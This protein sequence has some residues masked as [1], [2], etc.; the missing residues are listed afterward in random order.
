MDLVRKLVTLRV[1]SD[2]IPIAE[3]DA[4]EAAVVDGWEVIV[5]K[6]EFKVGDPCLFFEIDSWVP[7][8][9][10]PFLTKPGKTPKV[11]QDIPGA[12]LKTIRMRGQIS[13][14]LVLPVTRSLGYGTTNKSL[15][16]SADGT[17]ITHWFEEDYEADLTELF[18]VLHCDEPDDEGGPLPHGIPKTSQPRIQNITRQNRIYVD[19]GELFEWTEKLHGG[20]MTVFL[21]VGDSGDI[22]DMNYGVCSRNHA[23]PEED[24]AG[25][26]YWDAAEDQDLIEKLMRIHSE[27]GL[28]LALQGELVGEGMCKNYYKMKGR[29]FFLYDIYDIKGKRYLTPEERHAIANRYDIAHVPIIGCGY[30]SA[31]KD[32]LLGY[33]YGASIINPQVIKEGDVYKSMTRPDHSFKVVSNEFLVKQG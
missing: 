21:Y 32:T 20:S 12:R 18:G 29:T 13:Q 15:G 1:I 11:F 3:A 27:M 26:Y 23:I 6:D 9:I 16:F 7:H 4:I 30:A 25:S 2:L 24:K 8:S 22:E 10:A 31:P 17:N 19:R 5:K 14:G 33:A 28:S